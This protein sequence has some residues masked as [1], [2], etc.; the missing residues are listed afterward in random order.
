MS[1][2]QLTPDNVFTYIVENDYNNS[3][4]ELMRSN[5]ENIMYLLKD[6]YQVSNAVRNGVFIILEDLW[7]DASVFG[8]VVN[9]GTLIDISQEEADERYREFH[10]LNI[11]EYHLLTE[12][13]R[14]ELIRLGDEEGAEFGDEDDSSDTLS[15]QEREDVVSPFD[16][17]PSIGGEVGENNLNTSSISFEDIVES[18]SNFHTQ[19][20]Q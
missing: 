15:I 17:E 14:N 6:K 12:E 13:E 2:P 1:F 18:S 20:T 10:S 8:F 4:L 19:R 5:E 3:I 7:Q 9:S 11:R 16:L